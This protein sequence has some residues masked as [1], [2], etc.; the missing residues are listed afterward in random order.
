M[1][2]VVVVTGWVVGGVGGRVVGGAAGA[3]VGGAVVTGAAVVGGDEGD[4]GDEGDGSVV[5]LDDGAPGVVGGAVEWRLD[6]A[7]VGA[8]VPGLPVAPEVPVAPGPGGAPA[9]A[10]PRAPGDVVV[11]T[12]VVVADV[13]D[14]DEVDADD[15]AAPWARKATSR[16]DARPEPA[17]RLWVSWRTR[18]NR[19]RGSRFE[20]R[21]RMVGE[22]QDRVCHRPGPP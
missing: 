8:V 11:V 17:K 12:G 1:H 6:P 2:T 9:G 10:P 13:V 3:V 20:V 18:I 21:E 14:A 16:P 4:E 22:G 7:P 19:R 15:A 5:A